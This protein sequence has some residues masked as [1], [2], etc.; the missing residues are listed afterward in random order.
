MN[1]QSREPRPEATT[2][3][4]HEAG[5]A[6]AAVATHRTFTRLSIVPVN[7]EPTGCKWAAKAVADW[8]WI[9]CALAGPR[10]QVEFCPASLPDKKLALFRRSVLLRRKDWDLYS[11][12]GWFSGNP[13]KPMDLDPVLRLLQ[14][15]QWP[16]PELG[17]VTFGR[18]ISDVEETLKRFF[19]RPNTARAVTLVVDRLLQNPV[20]SEPQ[21]THVIQRVEQLLAPC[22]CSA[23]LPP[24]MSV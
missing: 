18:L 7:G 20:L 15:P 14:R 21:V 22:D 6:V 2:I 3:A 16:V 4:Y 24:C 10:A 8:V 9:S 23:I 12:T 11:F 17:A 13:E 5:H 1:L 19:R